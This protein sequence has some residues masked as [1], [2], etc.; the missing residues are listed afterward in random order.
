M[1]EMGFGLTDIFPGTPPEPTGFM[2]LMYKCIYNYLSKRL[3]E[4]SAEY[5]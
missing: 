5:N 2:Y 4:P 3:T 1:I